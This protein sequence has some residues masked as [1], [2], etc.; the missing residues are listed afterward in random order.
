MVLTLFWEKGNTMVGHDRVS[1]GYLEKHE[2]HI[3][4]FTRFM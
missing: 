1:D 4:K 2:R 3:T